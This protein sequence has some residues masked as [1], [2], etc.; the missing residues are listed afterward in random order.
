MLC[1]F[2]RPRL[3]VKHRALIHPLHQ[4]YG[5]PVI[6][7]SRLTYS[8]E[9]LRKDI[10]ILMSVHGAIKSGLE[11]ARSD[12][13][14]GSSLQS[15]VIIDVA[16]T[17][18]RNVLETYAD[19]LEAMFVVSSVGINATPPQDMEWSYTRDFEVGGDVKGKVVVLPPTQ[20]KC[21]RCWRYVAPEEDELCQRCEDVVATV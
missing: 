2:R 13:V 7:D 1:H 9:S 18:I 17:S 20:A 5:D 12:K 19:E 14:V 4:L 6:D 10:P 3:T 8:L 16:D 21:P 15:S 11:V